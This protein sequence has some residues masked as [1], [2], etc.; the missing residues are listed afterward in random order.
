MEYNKTYL[1]VQ[2]LRAQRISNRKIAELTGISK[3]SVSRLLTNKQKT[4][5]KE[6]EKKVLSTLK[7]KSYFKTKSKTHSNN[8]FEQVVK[9]NTAGYIA[10]YLAQT[11]NSYNV[12][13]KSK[14]MSKQ[15]DVFDYLEK[16]YKKFKEENEIEFEP[17]YMTSDILKEGLIEIRG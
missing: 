1:Y 17:Q 4:V 16:S 15:E 5:K 12:M 2:A 8:Y 13:R 14:K 10:K 9:I 3:S 7:K 6:T 11:N